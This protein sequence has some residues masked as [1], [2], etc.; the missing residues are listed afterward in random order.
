VIRVLLHGLTGPID[1][2]KYSEVMIP[3]GQ[4]TDEWIA[5]VGSYVRNAFGNSAPVITAAD[6]A[7]VRAATANRRTSWTVDEIQAALPRQLV[8][9]DWKLTASHNADTASYALTTQP[10][11]TGVPQQ[12]GMWLQVELAQPVML[13]EVQFEAGVVPP[14]AGRGGAASTVLGAPPRTDIAALGGGA[15]TIYGK[16]GTFE[17]QVSTDGKTWKRAAQGRAAGISTAVSFAPAQARFVRLALTV[18][19][20]AATP[21]AVQ[22]LKL[23]EAP[24]AR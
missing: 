22:R 24:S 4:N 2:E 21:W 12:A 3:M 13:S 8:Q 17:V 1:G 14:A 16:P 5:S 10:W 23:F 7:R 20:S 6:V 11:S 19:D 18:P 9:T 15:G